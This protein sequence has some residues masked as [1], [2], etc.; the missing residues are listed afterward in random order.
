MEGKKKKKTHMGV[1]RALVV[2]HKQINKH[3]K[4]GIRRHK[5]THAATH[6]PVIHLFNT[7]LV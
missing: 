5:N 4:T 7:V 2:K 6:E 1:C 3:K